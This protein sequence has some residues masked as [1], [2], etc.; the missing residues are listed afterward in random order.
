MKT[1]IYK[2]FLLP[3]LIFWMTLSVSGQQIPDS[4]VSYLE[5]A[6]M[7]NP[8]VRQ[9]FYEYQ[10]ALQ[11]IP[12]VG[13]LPDPEISAGVFLQPM[14]LVSGNQIADVRLMQMFPWFGTLRSAKDEMSLMANAKYE[15]FRDAKLQVYYD[16]QRTWYELY[17]IRS[18]ISISE[19]NIEI[20]KTIERLA[21]VKFQ[22]APFSGE[23]SA[24]GSSINNTNSLQNT[25]SGSSLFMQS[26]DGS[27]GTSAGTTSMQSS[28][29]M[30]SG[31]MESS[32][33][34]SGLA[35]LYRIQIEIGDL[36][37]NI[38]LSKDQNVTITAQFNSYL[39]RLPVTP[40]FTPD[41]LNADTLS[42]ALIS[43][44]DSILTNNPML[45][46]LEFE[47][48]SYEARKKMVKKMGYPM[49]GVGLNYS[50][51]SQSEMSE[52]SMNGRDMI[53]PMVSVSLPVYR[54][55]FNAMA[56]EA[57]LLETAAANSF[58]AEANSLQTEFYQAVQMYQDAQ[59]RVMLYNNQFQLAS[60]TLAIILKD[61]A[62]S[63]STLT[64]LLRI[65]QQTFEYELKQAEA[66]ADLNIATALLK[67]LMASSQIN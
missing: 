32:S 40:V 62:V 28:Q 42:M 12:Q 1:K 2:R 51:I 15:L 55:K 37:N 57:D 27:Q 11:K 39:N 59:R 21:I 16:V 25:G 17:K 60:K 14:E 64:D 44:S 61:F 35:D 41:T 29:S 8:V 49:I 53:M 36:Q 18:D 31:A 54:K 47:K 50:F 10:A 65:R 63:S 43:V 56:T 6:A 4:L 48:Q 58:T 23:V 67:R 19:K 38:A 52:S 34:M 5:I 45:T 9:K 26:M 30:Q 46:M 3:F 24:S 20:L 13:G 33:G 66:I 22:A 7:K